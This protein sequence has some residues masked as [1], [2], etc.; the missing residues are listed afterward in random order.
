MS[1]S[2]S[3]KLTQACPGWLAGFTAIMQL[4]EASE[5][6]SQNSHVTF[7]HLLWPQVTRAAS[8]QGRRNRPCLL[9]GELWRLVA[10]SS[11]CYR[12]L[13]CCP[14]LSLWIWYALKTLLASF[15]VILTPY[16]S[17]P[18]NLSFQVTSPVNV[19]TRSSDFFPQIYIDVVT[20]HK[21]CV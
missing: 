16:K 17:F 2:S 4:C 1:L 12:P 9:I 15:T 13:F 14:L 8:S 11:V 7:F 10:I 6:P 5:G 21:S 3:N 19:E 18:A 20:K